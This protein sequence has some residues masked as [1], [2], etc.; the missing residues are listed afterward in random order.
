MSADRD[1][2]DHPSPRTRTPTRTGRLTIQR[3]RRIGLHPSFRRVCEE[4]LA[5]EVEKRA[6]KRLDAVDDPDAAD[7]CAAF[8]AAYREVALPLWMEEVGW[9]T[10]DLEK[11]R[12]KFRDHLAGEKPEVRRAFVAA[13]V[14]EAGCTSLGA[15]VG[16]KRDVLAGVVIG[17]REDALRALNS[18]VWLP[19]RKWVAAWAATK[20]DDTTILARAQAVWIFL[21]DVPAAA[22]R[23]VDGL[24][25]NWIGE[26]ES[27]RY[28]DR[29][30]AFRKAA[31][32]AR[33]RR[34]PSGAEARAEAAL[35]EVRAVSDAHD[36]F[37][38]FADNLLSL[39]DP[40][41]GRSRVA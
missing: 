1:P 38:T 5:D 17:K 15:D 39:I 12:A 37:F 2:K 24:V 22:F 25:E 13:A 23:A 18:R 20:T 33:G 16:P 6:L 27:R 40:R 3:H 21:P 14:I 11:A 31:E 10:A 30:Q 41:G 26:E 8:Y 34:A 9:H 35:A 7:V 19:F 32:E 29:Y 36:A 4:G 28:V